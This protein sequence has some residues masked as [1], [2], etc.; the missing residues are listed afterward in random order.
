MTKL[1]LVAALVFS[2]LTAGCPSL[3]P[4]EL[5]PLSARHSTAPETGP[6][7][8]SGPAPGTPGAA[9]SSDTGASTGGATGALRD[10]QFVLLPKGPLDGT[11]SSESGRVSAEPPGALPAGNPPHEDTTAG[12]IRSGTPQSSQPALG[13]S[14][15][16]TPTSA[17]EGPLS[18]DRCKNTGPA[19]QIALFQVA[20]GAILATPKGLFSLGTTG[21]WSQEGG[22]FPCGTVPNAVVRSSTGFIYAAAGDGIYRLTSPFEAWSR[23][24]E[25]N[26]V[27]DLD[28]LPEATVGLAIQEDGFPLVFD[29]FNWRLQNRRLRPSMGSVRVLSA[30]ESYALGPDALGL[31][32]GN[33]WSVLAPPDAENPIA[34][35]AVR[36]GS[37]SSLVVTTRSA[38]YHR[39]GANSW[40]A[41]VGPNS[42]YYLGTPNFLGSTGI[43]S[44]LVAP[45][46]RAFKA[47][48]SVWTEVF[49]D[50]LPIESVAITAQGEVV[51]LGEDGQSVYR[52]VG[53]SWRSE[54][55][56]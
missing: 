27:A 40:V 35:L 39:S 3:P 36:R 1:S 29:G 25:A 43:V 6:L 56:P 30:T 34:G 18:S 7:S 21:S 53:S 45:S 22:K 24:V 37:V 50:A 49:L 52:L 5:A 13:S 23:E 33:D 15:G 11:S 17:G 32:N 44:D 41:E 28:V 31:W 55:L 19:G 2:L 48:G 12:A 54:P 42:S 10:N 26:S 47:M 4:D 51:A 46:G 8:Q 14:S 20:S 9:T 38:I 16:T